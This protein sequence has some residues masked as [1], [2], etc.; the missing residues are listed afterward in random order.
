MITIR[1]LYKRSVYL[2]YYLYRMDWPKFRKFF[3]VARTA[4][5]RNAL[6]LWVDVIS[7]VYR[8]NIGLID[9]FYFRFFEKAPSERALWVGTG[10]KYEYDLVM[11]PV[12]ARH[13][14]Q[15]KIHFFDAYAP[16]V[17][18]AMC[19]IDDLE[20]NN[21]AAARVLSNASGKIAIKDAL[22]QCGWD[23]EIKRADELSRTELIGYMRGKGFNMAEE[24]I[25]QHPELSRL[26][27]TG[28]NTVRIIT[29]LNHKDEVAF[30]GPTLRITV[31]SPVDN[32]AVG[33]IAAPIDIDTGIIRGPGAYQDITK[34]AESA[35]P[36]TGV[37]LVGFQVPHWEKVKELCR[38]AALHNTSN[39]SIAWDVAITRDGPSFVE[40]NHNWCKLLWQLPAGEGLKP[41][42]DYYLEDYL[43]N[44]PAS[45]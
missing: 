36:V 10:Y 5:N 43:T 3:N 7:C 29:Q 31:N 35:H 42:L 27:D 30:L 6:S 9:Y 19:T 32:M 20:E 11:N 2:A 4:G 38:T 40:G 25:V 37:S 16:F 39:R 44:K 23:V 24:F 14:L 22:G 12:D 26:S 45:S 17:K 18:H 21:D 1:N 33:N 34:E 15:N 28:L 41:V 8:Y 13:I